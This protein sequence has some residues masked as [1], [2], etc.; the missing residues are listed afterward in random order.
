MQIDTT[1]MSSRGQIVIPLDMRR[2]IK[3]GDKL[4]VIRN[5]DDL[6]IKKSIPE[7][8]LASHKSLAKTWLTKEEDNAWKD[9]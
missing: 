8:L 3:E 1:K 6:I 4:I 5:G 2:D 9:L 7:I